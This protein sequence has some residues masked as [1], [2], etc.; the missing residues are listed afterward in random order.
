MQG[1][2]IVQPHGRQRFV[3]KIYHGNDGVY[4]CAAHSVA[5]ERSIP[6]ILIAQRRIVL[7]PGSRVL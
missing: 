2:T 6:G 4:S 7:V 3:S 5:L 1:R